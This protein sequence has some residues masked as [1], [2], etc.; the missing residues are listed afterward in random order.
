MSFF[1]LFSLFSENWRIKNNAHLPL[2][3]FSEWKGQSNDVKSKD[4]NWLQFTFSRS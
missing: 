4:A 2:E 3:F 1:C